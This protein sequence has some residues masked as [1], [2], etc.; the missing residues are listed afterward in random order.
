LRTDR[1]RVRSQDDDAVEIIAELDTDQKGGI[2]VAQLEA[3]PK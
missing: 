1:V 3:V 2:S